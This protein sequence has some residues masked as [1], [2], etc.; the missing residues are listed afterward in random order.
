MY[1]RWSSICSSTETAKLTESSVRFVELVK[2]TLNFVDNANHEE[3]TLGSGASV[4]IV[5]FGH[6]MSL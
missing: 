2:I 5:L 4:G 1:G 3:R 6:A